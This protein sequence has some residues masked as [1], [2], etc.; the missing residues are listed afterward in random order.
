MGDSL[1][2]MFDDIEFTPTPQDAVNDARLLWKKPHE[3][4][5]RQHMR[6][7]ESKRPSEMTEEEK[8]QLREQ[9]REN[10]PN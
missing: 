3:R 2:H 9:H 10:A 1:Y 8:A 4:H 7:L 5:M 6:A